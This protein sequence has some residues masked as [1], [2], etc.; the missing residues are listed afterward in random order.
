VFESC[1]FCTGVVTGVTIGGGAFGF[2]FEE[3]F[4]R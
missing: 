2:F 3:V 4:A 1:H